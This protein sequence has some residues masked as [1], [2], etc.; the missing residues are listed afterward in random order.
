MKYVSIDIETTGLNP[1]KCAILSIGAVIEDTKKE[2][3]I[4]H[5]P[6]FHAAI[7]HRSGFYGEP[8]A[9]NMNKN[10]IETIMRYEKPGNKHVDKEAIRIESGMKFFQEKAIIREFDSWLAANGLN[11]ST[12]VLFAGKNIENFDIKFLERL[13]GWNV[14][15]KL[16]RTIDPAILYVDY[17]RDEHPPSLN[18]CKRRAIEMG[19]DINLEVQHNAL[20]DALDVVKLIR[21]AKNNLKWK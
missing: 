4:E 5:L 18:E 9:L 21:F 15:H 17:E 19:L 3:P 8:F 14:I 16:N 6:K 13:P 2:L 10:L 1:N 7:I 20:E 11:I 12:P